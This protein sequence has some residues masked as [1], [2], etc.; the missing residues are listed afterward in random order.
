MQLPSK[1]PCLESVSNALGTAGSSIVGAFGPPA[2]AAGGAAASLLVAS[3]KA[4]SELAS[5]MAGGSAVNVVAGVGGVYPGAAASTAALH[6]AAAAPHLQAAIDPVSQQ[7]APGIKAAAASTQAGDVPGRDGPA[8]PANQALFPVAEPAASVPAAALPY[9]HASGGGIGETSADEEEDGSSERDDEKGEEDSDDEEEHEADRSKLPCWGMCSCQQLRG[10]HSLQP[11]T[12]ACAFPRGLDAEAAWFLQPERLVQVFGGEPMPAPLGGVPVS[13]R[14]WVGLKAEVGVPARPRPRLTVLRISAQYELAVPLATAAAAGA[15]AGAAAAGGEAGGGGEGG[16]SAPAV[17]VN[18]SSCD[19]SPGLLKL[20]AGAPVM[21]IANRNAPQFRKHIEPHLG[22]VLPTNA[23]AKCCVYAVARVRRVVERSTTP[24]D[25]APTQATQTRAGGP[26]PRLWVE[27]DPA[28]WVWLDNVPWS[29]ITL[30]TML[31]YDPTSAQLLAESPEFR[32]YVTEVERLLTAAK[33]AAATGGTPARPWLQPVPDGKF[34]NGFKDPKRDLAF[35]KDNPMAVAAAKRTLA[36]AGIE[37]PDAVMAAGGSGDSA[38]DAAKA[39]RRGRGTGAA[40]KEASRGRKASGD[41]ASRPQRKERRVAAKRKN[42][43]DLADDDEADATSEESEESDQPRG[44]QPAQPPCHE[45]AAAPAAQAAAEAEA[46]RSAVANAAAAPA[47]ATG[48]AVIAAV[49]MGATPA[50]CIDSIMFR[51]MAKMDALEA[52]A[53]NA[54]ARAADVEL[55]N[56]QLQE[57]VQELE[58]QVQANVWAAE[59]LQQVETAR[60]VALARAATAEMK[61]QEVIAHASFWGDRV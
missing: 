28:S 33:D 56:R 7:V 51:A 20:R 24:D 49:G 14:C 22:H 2:K 38:A 15:A 4:P 52:R 34:L 58:R 25:C 45:A 23:D 18:A 5:V 1:R 59:R 30:D 50:R 54:E 17:G 13:K 32:H 61:V 12:A 43:V 9:A 16:V 19:T 31:P 8:A 27:L 39:G 55:Q 53:K 29:Q 26:A 21:L 11:G 3:A 35:T 40:G 46:G 47:A 57:R 41:A 37:V 42:V 10:F 44:E 36:A 48:G 6:G 60:D